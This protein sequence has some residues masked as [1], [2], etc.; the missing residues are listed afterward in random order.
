MSGKKCKYC[1]APMEQGQQVCPTC[2]IDNIKDKKQLTMEEVNLWHSAR[3]LNVVSILAV[4]GGFLG[5]MA[6]LALLAPSS[7]PMPVIIPV[8]T[9]IF[10]VTGICVGI[11]IRKRQQWT[12]WGG[13][14]LYGLLLLIFFSVGRWLGMIIFACFIYVIAN[15]T[16][17]KI[18]YKKL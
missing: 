4:I 1:F 3:N 8:R 15:P 13:I 16:A 9:F 18:L 11:G 5:I 17:K 14:I 7:H 10:A 6:T 2:R 12:Y